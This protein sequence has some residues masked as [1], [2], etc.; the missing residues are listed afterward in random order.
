MFNQSI[1]IISICKIIKQDK[2][3]SLPSTSKKGAMTRHLYL[4]T[5]VA[6]S[7]Q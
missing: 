4:V 1:I 7:Q 5:W 2:E 3:Y 6:M